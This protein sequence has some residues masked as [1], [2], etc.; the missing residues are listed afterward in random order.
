MIP[1]ELTS[2]IN[3]IKEY[4]WIEISVAVVFYV[5]YKNITTIKTFLINIFT[6]SGWYLVFKSKKDLLIK[7][8][9]HILFNTLKKVSTEINYVAFEYP[10]KTAMFRDFMQQNILAVKKSMSNL[11]NSKDVLTKD[12]SQL[13]SEVINSIDDISIMYTKTTEEIFMKKGLTYEESKDIIELFIE[14]MKPSRDSLE[15]L[16]THYFTNEEYDNYQLLYMVLNH[17][18]HTT[19]LIPTD[20]VKSFNHL[21]GR[22]TKHTYGLPIVD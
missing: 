16:T 6:S 19:M 3:L 8:N 22:F 1:K 12:K 15:Y 4:T 18:A 21:N 9:N 5:I 13:L 2:I 11:I 20:G 14:F 10:Q 17:I 7:L